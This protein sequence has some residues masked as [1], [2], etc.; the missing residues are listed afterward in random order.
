MRQPDDH[1]NFRHRISGLHA[2]VFP[3]NFIRISFSALVKCRLGII[4]RLSL[5]QQNE[6]RRVA[7]RSAAFFW[8]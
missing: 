7:F 5:I 2:F 3:N 4:S 6:K 8:F 1:R